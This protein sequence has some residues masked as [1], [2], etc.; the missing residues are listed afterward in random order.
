MLSKQRPVVEVWEDRLVLARISKDCISV[1]MSSTCCMRRS[2]SHRSQ[3]RQPMVR[4][5]LGPVEGV[6]V[7]RVSQCFNMNLSSQQ[8]AVHSAYFVR[9]NRKV[10][11]DNDL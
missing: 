3:G 5:E 8:I 7:D 4:G 11:S 6:G 2:P 10:H 9:K 1:T